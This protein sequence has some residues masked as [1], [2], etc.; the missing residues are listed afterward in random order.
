MFRILTGLAFCI[1]AGTS[2]K[3]DWVWHSASQ[4]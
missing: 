2:S 4:F 3:G 1:V